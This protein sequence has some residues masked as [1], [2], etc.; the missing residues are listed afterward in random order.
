MQKLVYLLF[1]SVLFASCHYTASPKEKELMVTYKVTVLRSD[2]AAFATMALPDEI[3]FYHSDS[4]SLVDIQTIIGNI[5]IRQIGDSKSGNNA[6]V[7]D[8]FNKRIACQ[9]KEP[10][11]YFL[12]FFNKVKVTDL[13]GD[14]VIQNYNCKY[15][16]IVFE[17]NSTANYTLLYSPLEGC[18]L[19]NQCTPYQDIAGLIMRFEMHSPKL[20]LQ[21]VGSSF[22]NEAIPDSLFE[23]PS[24]YDKVSPATMRSILLSLFGSEI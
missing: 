18:N 17:E 3:F 2:L 14:T 10:S 12:P 9:C 22:S 11:F 23:I 24:G 20:D 6:I 15:K 1:I 7:L 13:E 8:Y 16:N 5:R 19:I 4:K 21:L